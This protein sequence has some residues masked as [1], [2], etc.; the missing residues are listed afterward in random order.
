MKRLQ[1]MLTIIFLLILCAG[2]TTKAVSEQKQAIL[3][4][5]E[6]A[7]SVEVETDSKNLTE[8]A[9][10]K[11]K[12]SYIIPQANVE[13][14]YALEDFLVYWAD[15]VM[16][17][18]QSDDYIITERYWQGSEDYT[19]TQLIDGEEKPVTKDIIFHIT[20]IFEFD[21]SGKLIA[22]REKYTFQTDW[23]VPNNV[24]Y[25]DMIHRSD[26]TNV[27]L[28]EQAIYADVASDYLEKTKTKQDFVNEFAAEDRKYYM[29]Q[30]IEAEQ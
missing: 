23:G 29:S 28:V 24:Y 5:E 15:E 25:Q 10:E 3:D 2:C 27:K 21:E 13:Q 22:Q 19:A 6:E 8:T 9:Q 18:P 20:R 11:E 26:Y 4:S 16:F 7:A 14:Y 12:P 30:P 1:I 17:V